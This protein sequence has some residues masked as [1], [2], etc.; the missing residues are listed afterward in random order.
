VRAL[1]ATRALL[2][3]LGLGWFLWP[4]SDATAP[5]AD[6]PRPTAP[7]RS[8]LPIVTRARWPASSLQRVLELPGRTRPP[9]TTLTVEPGTFVEHA[10][11]MTDR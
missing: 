6:T 5:A 8:P 3:V 10:T 1:A 11:G 7:E 2:F 9:E 4:E